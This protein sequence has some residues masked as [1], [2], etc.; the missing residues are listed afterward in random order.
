MEEDGKGD[1]VFGVLTTS[2]IEVIQYQ[3][4]GVVLQSVNRNEDPFF[5]A[6]ISIEDYPDVTIVGYDSQG[7][8]RG[9]SEAV[10]RRDFIAR[11]TGDGH[12][13]VKHTTT[14]LQR[15]TPESTTRN[16]LQSAAARW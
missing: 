12:Y 2:R 3:A 15:V 5:Q 11:P 9:V 10:V 7:A 8:V 1:A 13:S 4:D 6:Q 14:R 16:S